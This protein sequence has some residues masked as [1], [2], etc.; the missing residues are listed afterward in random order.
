VV[1]PFLC[2]GWF[3]FLHGFFGLVCSVWALFPACATWFPV[4]SSLSPL[5][6]IVTPLSVPLSDVTACQSRLDVQWPAQELV[7]QEVKDSRHNHKQHAQEEAQWKNACKPN[8]Q[9]QCV[10]DSTV[11]ATCSS[12]VFLSC[13]K[14]KRKGEGWKREE[15][16]QE[17]KRQSAVFYI[18]SKKTTS[19]EKIR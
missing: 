13:Y 11:Q 7:C 15:S 3:V 12:A 6:L 5:L 19:P 4:T 17:T 10:E 16:K 18:T 8:K 14:D 1:V 2:S 9:W